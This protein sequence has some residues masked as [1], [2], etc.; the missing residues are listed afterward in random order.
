MDTAAVIAEAFEQ[1]H[2]DFKAVARRARAR[3]VQQDW[4]GVQD[5][6]AERLMLYKQALESNLPRVRETL[7]G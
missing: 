4:H 7:G 1:W 3:F 6:A 5:D 2:E